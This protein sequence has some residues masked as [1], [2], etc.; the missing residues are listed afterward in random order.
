MILTLFK[1]AFKDATRVNQ[2]L[3]GEWVYQQTESEQQEVK[4]RVQEEHIEILN[5]FEIITSSFPEQI[6]EAVRNT[7]AI[8]YL[9]N[10]YCIVKHLYLLTI[11]IDEN[12]R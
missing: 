8:L 11:N 1:K 4:V 5:N 3:S 6:L 10:S 7:S 12:R 9:S 2:M